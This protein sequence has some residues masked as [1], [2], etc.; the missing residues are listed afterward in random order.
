LPRAEPVGVSNTASSRSAPADL[1]TLL[2]GWGQ[3]R[4]ND[5]KWPVFDGKYVNYPR[6]KKEWVAHRETYHSIVNND[7]AAK[8]LREKYMKGDRWKMVGHLEDLKD[9]W[10]TLDTCYERHEKYMEEVLKPILEFRKYR[11]FNNSAVREFYSILQ[12]NGRADLLINDQTIPKIMGKMPFANWKE[13][14]IKQPKWIRGNL[15]TAFEAYVERKWKD[16]LNVAAAEP[17]GWEVD[18]TKK[19]RGYQEKPAWGRPS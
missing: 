2:R 11:V 5:S 6:F 3:L 16:A 18:A 10:E 7:L 14:T 17:R 19:D 1:A 13:W 4:A 9:I 15:E 8:T 12:A